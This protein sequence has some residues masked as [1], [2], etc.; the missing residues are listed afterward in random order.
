MWAVLR[1]SGVERLGRPPRA[2]CIRHTVQPSTPGLRHG[3]PVRLERAVQRLP[4]QPGPRLAP[5]TFSLLIKQTVTFRFWP[6]TR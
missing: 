1:Q 6:G 3:L 4:G 2:P 5:A